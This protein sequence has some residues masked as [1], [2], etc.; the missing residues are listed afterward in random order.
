MIDYFT[1]RIK[2]CPWRP[3][4]YAR[5]S[6]VMVVDVEDEFGEMHVTRHVFN[7]ERGGGGGAQL[8]IGRIVLALNMIE[9]FQVKE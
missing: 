8:G 4:N 9:F 3:G 1:L 2:Y 6:R 7:L 5:G